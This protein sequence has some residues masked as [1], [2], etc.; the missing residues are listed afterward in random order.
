MTGCLLNPS[1]HKVYDNTRIRTGSNGTTFLFQ[2]DT[3]HAALG[4]AG[5]VTGGYVS[6][7]AC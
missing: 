7:D 4:K 2:D 5:K 6:A 3:V 1:L